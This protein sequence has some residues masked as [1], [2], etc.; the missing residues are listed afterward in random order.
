VNRND[1][2][3]FLVRIN[4][5]GGLVAKIG[6][7]K[8]WYAAPEEKSRLPI[9]SEDSPHSIFAISGRYDRPD[10]SVPK[11]SG[12][13]LRG[14]ALLDR[15]AFFSEVVEMLQN[16]AVVALEA[17]RTTQLLPE[18]LRPVERPCSSRAQ[19]DAPA[20]NPGDGFLATS[21]TVPLVSI[22]CEA[23]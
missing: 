23:Q 9:A 19:A 18:H 12:A 10:V 17:A 4:V 22:L 3:G 15:H 2:P 21:A 14:I 1:S 5:A 6:N 20:P 11:I 8:C 7:Q 16:V 13:H